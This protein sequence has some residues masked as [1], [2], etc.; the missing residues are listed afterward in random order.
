MFKQLLTN[1]KIVIV[2]LAVILALIVGIVIL[3]TPNTKGTGNKDFDTKTEQSKEDANSKDDEKQTDKEGGSTGLEILE[4]DEVVPE[5]SSNA[6]G[7]WGNTSNSNTQTGNTTEKTDKTEEQ[8]PNE[9]QKDEDDK[10][11]T[12]Q[13]I[14]EDDISWGNI[15]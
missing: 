13:D 1:K 12:V 8:K 3:V 7:S 6:S 2:V 14:L 9:N 11:E 10:S 4:P 15:Y 5:D